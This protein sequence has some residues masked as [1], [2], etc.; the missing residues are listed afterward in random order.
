MRGDD[1][2]TTLLIG[3]VLSALGFL[4]LPAIVV[5]GYMV[6]VLA[7]A[8]RGEST[9]PAFDR[10]GELFVDGLK[11]IAVVFV[12]L[13]APMAASL[14]L[15]LAVGFAG[16]GLV[17][18]AVGGTAGAAGTVVSLL[19][20]VLATYL[21]PAG[22]TNMAREDSIAAAFDLSAVGTAATSGTYLLAVVAAL[23]VG[24]VLGTIGGILSLLL[25]GFVV[26]FYS[27]VVAYCLL[28]SAV[29]KA[30]EGGRSTPGYGAN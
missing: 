4:I 13:F 7:A 8:S 1:W 6:R 5:N 2:I 22:L 29:G 26:T 18:D 19:V 28:G 21:L 10:W 23:L 17:G 16:F 24:I 14:G 9:P 3:T 25:V 12:Y 20:L 30:L 27:Q 11:L 15:S